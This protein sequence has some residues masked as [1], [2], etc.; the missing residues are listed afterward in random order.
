MQT[1]ETIRINCLLIDIDNVDILQIAVLKKDTHIFY[2]K[3]LLHLSFLQAQEKID[4]L[5]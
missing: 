5:L 1:R 4:N 3:L 2:Y